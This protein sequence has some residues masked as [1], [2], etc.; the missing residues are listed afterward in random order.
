MS[1]VS[2]SRYKRLIRVM[3][4]GVADTPTKCRDLRLYLFVFYIEDHIDNH[5]FLQTT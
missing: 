1:G 4:L 5:F 2:I 3:Y